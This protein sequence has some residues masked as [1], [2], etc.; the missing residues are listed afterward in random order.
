MT[1]QLKDLMRLPKEAQIEVIKTLF[2]YDECHI[3]S[4]IVC[5]EEK[6]EVVTSYAL[7][8]R[9]PEGFELGA[10]FTQKGLHLDYTARKVGSNMWEAMTGAWEFMTKEEKEIVS[11]SQRVIVKAYAV[12]IQEQL[13]NQYLWDMEN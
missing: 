2:F 9:Y 13:Y 10:R 8:A 1:N 7:C 6:I 5:G 12:K 4:R 11:N 3:E